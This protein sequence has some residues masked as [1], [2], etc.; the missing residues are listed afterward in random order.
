MA[1]Q[2]DLHVLQ[3]IPCTN[4]LHVLVPIFSLAYQLSRSTDELEAEEPE[5][6]EEPSEDEEDPWEG[7][8]DPNTGKCCQLPLR[9]SN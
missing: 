5:E 6:L 9:D 3:A 1:K 8:F 4:R 2:V 7:F